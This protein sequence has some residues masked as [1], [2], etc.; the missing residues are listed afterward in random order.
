MNAKHHVVVVGDV[1]VDHHIYEGERE[2]PTTLKCRGLREIR[3]TGGAATLYRLLDAVRRHGGKTDWEATLGVVEPKTDDSPATHHAFAT[4]R[5]FALEPKDESGEASDA[6]KHAAKKVWRAHL[7]LGYGEETGAPAATAPYV[8]GVR[9]DLPKPD[10]LVLD[11]GGFQFRLAAQ[12][13]SWLLPKKGEAAWILLKM[14]DPI[15]RGDLWHD[16]DPDFL[17]RVVCLISAADLRREYVA[18]SSGLSWERSVDDLRN[19]FR[20][21]HLLSRLTRCRHLIVTLSADC[22]LWLDRPNDDPPSATLFF[23]ADGAEGEW[24]YRLGGDVVGSMTAI[25]ASLAHALVRQVADDDA[26]PD[27]AFAIESGLRSMRDLMQMGHGF[28]DDGQKPSGY[29][30]ERIAEIIARERDGRNEFAVARLDWATPGQDAQWSIMETSQRPLGFPLPST[31]TGLARLVA[32]KGSRALEQLP[33]AKFGKLITADRQEIETLRSIR[34][35]MIAYRDD[36]S[37]TKPLSIGV[38]GPPGAG[39]S[40][41]VQQIAH[42]LF[43]EEAWLEF[44]LSQFSGPDD[45]LGAFHKSRD[46]VLAGKTPIVFWDEFDSGN[47]KWLQYLLAPLQDGRFQQGQLNHAVGRGVFVFAGGTTFTYEA[48]GLLAEPGAPG[49]QERILA[50]VPDF[51]TRLDAYYDVRGPNPRMRHGADKPDSDAKTASAG[52]AATAQS[53]EWKPDPG[54]VGYPLRRALFIRS[55]LKCGAGQTLDFDPGLVDALLFVPKYK[56]GAR[57]LEKM[58]LPLRQ[59][60]GGPIRR[61]SLPAPAQIAMHVDFD[62]FSSILDRNEQFRIEE[63]IEEIAEKIHNTWLKREHAAGRVPDESLNC[64]YKKLAEIAKEDNRAAARRIPDVLS[65]ADLGVTKDEVASAPSADQIEEQIEHCLERLAEAEHDGWVEQRVRN[66][67][68]FAET[69][70]DKVRHH[71]MIKEYDKLPEENKAKGSQLRSKL[72]AA[73]CRSRLSHRLVRSGASASAQAS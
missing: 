52:S 61:S 13:S 29:P 14:S 67:W 51:F 1:I 6:K 9:T 66:G 30:K 72:S 21:N 3:E 41:G 11:D 37:K 42:E 23:D 69:R 35:L 58:V 53:V 57:S 32:I 12:R 46:L 70:N 47:Y 71:P 59:E 43:G 16:L 65:F 48:F 68:V 4:W 44:N 31:A 24:A 64:E 38:F 73:D 15:A 39:K 40:F 18:L 54:D 5:P 26:E 17:H 50:K 25:A 33:H 7:K 2:K 34:R 20:E 56:H 27:L 36:K 28:V 22:A 60:H 55:K 45:L 63:K 10:V 62:A 19:A 8:P 49:W